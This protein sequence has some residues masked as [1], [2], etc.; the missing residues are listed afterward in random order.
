MQFLLLGRLGS[1]A[2][3]LGEGKGPGMWTWLWFL[4]IWSWMPRCFLEPLVVCAVSFPG[5]SIR[6]CGQCSWSLGL[7]VPPQ[8]LGP[9]G[10]GVTTTSPL[11]LLLHAVQS[12]HLQM[13]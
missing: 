12:T 2:P 11:V 10:L 7:R 1:Q 3:L 5:A 9:P 4:S 8:F 13:D 6:R